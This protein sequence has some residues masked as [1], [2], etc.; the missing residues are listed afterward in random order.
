MLIK[1]TKIITAA[2]FMLATSALSTIAGPI[3]DRIEAGET[4]RIGFSNIPIWAYPDDE[5][6]PTGSS[7]TS[8]PRHSRTWDTPILSPWL[9]TG[10][11]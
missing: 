2:T 11:G 8:P 1:L 5:A 4:I 9:L 7:M 6:M 3:E 10:A